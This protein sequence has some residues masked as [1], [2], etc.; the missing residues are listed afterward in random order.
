M[1]P[2][3]DAVRNAGMTRLK[4][5]LGSK[6]D[7]ATTNIPVC[8]SPSASAII[9]RSGISPTTRT[10]TKPIAAGAVV[11]R[12]RMSGLSSSPAVSSPKP[13]LAARLRFSEGS[14]RRSPY[15]PALASSTVA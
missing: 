14:E 7:A 15:K 12:P 9:G 13:R 4:P 3:I 2:A 10:Y 5:T 1:V 8:A 6:R 11:K